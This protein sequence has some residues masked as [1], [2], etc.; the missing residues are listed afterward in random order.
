MAEF[1]DP[2][3]P[4]KLSDLGILIDRNWAAALAPYGISSS[5]W[6]I[7]ATLVER[8]SMTPVEVGS[9]VTLEQSLISRTAQRLYEKR[10]ITRR[11]SRSDRRNV[12]LRATEDGEELIRQLE[13]PLQELA[14][15]LTRGISQRRFRQAA[16]VV[17]DMLDNME[18]TPE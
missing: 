1:P 8:G 12:T 10:L 18:S 2:R 9:L 7:L 13:Q 16:G 11:R 14:D 6:R 3:M 5:E 15:E 4:Q 17:A